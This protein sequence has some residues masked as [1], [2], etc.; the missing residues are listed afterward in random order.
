M[1]SKSSLLA[2]AKHLPYNLLLRIFGCFTYQFLFHFVLYEM[3]LGIYH[4]CQNTWAYTMTVI[5][6]M[7]TK[8]TMMA[9]AMKT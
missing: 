9:A 8:Y 2:D 6:V 3:S 1:R 5:T 4:F 7:S